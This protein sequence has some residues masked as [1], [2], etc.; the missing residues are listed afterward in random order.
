MSSPVKTP[1]LIVELGPDPDREVKL[2]DR[3]VLTPLI[4]PKAVDSSKTLKIEDGKKEKTVAFLNTTLNVQD[5]PETNWAEGAKIAAV[6]IAVAAFVTGVIGL[7]VHLD[8]LQLGITNVG[9]MSGAVGLYTLLSGFGI[10]GLTAIL[11]GVY[12]CISCANEKA[13]TRPLTPPQVAGP[14]VTFTLEPQNSPK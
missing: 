10:A 11:L 13:K 5:Q 4:S 6:A 3:K 2:G 9:M 7:L 14:S 8:I 12:K 1:K